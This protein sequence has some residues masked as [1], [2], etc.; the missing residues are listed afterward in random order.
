MCRIAARSRYGTV[1]QGST[2][3][4]AFPTVEQIDFS[5]SEI[6]LKRCRRTNLNICRVASRESWFRKPAFEDGNIDRAWYPSPGTVDEAT[7]SVVWRPDKPE[8]RTVTPAPEM[9][10]EA[11]LQEP[12]KAGAPVIARIA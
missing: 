4:V 3:W 2:V 6:L 9:G 11:A 7:G 10:A 1:C 8:G 12:G 5:K